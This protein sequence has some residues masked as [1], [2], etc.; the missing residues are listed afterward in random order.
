MLVQMWLVKNCP[1]VSALVDR[2]IILPHILPKVEIP[3]INHP[4]PYDP[5][6][7]CLPITHHSF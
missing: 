6:H 4:T 3:N 1:Y 7:V 5:Y 2:S